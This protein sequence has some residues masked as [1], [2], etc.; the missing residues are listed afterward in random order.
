[1]K[2]DRNYF[3]SN[4]DNEI[5]NINDFDSVISE[6]GKSAEIGEWT[7]EGLRVNDEVCIYTFEEIIEIIKELK[8]EL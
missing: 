6:D 7:S 5:H 1:M 8:I 4:H 3:F 2:N